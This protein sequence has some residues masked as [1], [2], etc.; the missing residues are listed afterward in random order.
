MS[1]VLTRSIHPGVLAYDRVHGEMLR[2]VADGK[3]SVNGLENLIT[4]RIDLEDFVEGGEYVPLANFGAVTFTNAVA[5]STTYGLAGPG[6]ST[7]FDI[8]QNGVVYTAVTVA[9]GD[10]FITYQ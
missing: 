6:Y 10:V 9:Y 4:R 2:A 3:L 8:E 5:T 7:V 1:T